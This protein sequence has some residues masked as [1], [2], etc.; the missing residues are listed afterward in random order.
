MDQKP[1]ISD[2]DECNGTSEYPCGSNTNCTNVDGGYECQCKDGFYG[3][4]KQE[5]V[6]KFEI[7]NNFHY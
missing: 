4:P 2:V 3:D 1:Q 6:G 5:C 7:L